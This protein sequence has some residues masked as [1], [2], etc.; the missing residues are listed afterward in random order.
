[1]ENHRGEHIVNFTIGAVS[2][3]ERGGSAIQPHCE[4]Y[5]ILSALSLCIVGASSHWSLSAR[6]QPYQDFQWHTRE[7]A[8]LFAGR[9]CALVDILFS[10]CLYWA[11]R[12][13]DHLTGRSFLKEGS[14]MI[15]PTRLKVRAIARP[16]VPVRASARDASTNLTAYPCTE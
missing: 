2:A 11:W 9:D 16:R 4:S 1:M 5:C 8:C 13:R 12:G 14:T 15:L 7:I 10:A 3:I 6:L